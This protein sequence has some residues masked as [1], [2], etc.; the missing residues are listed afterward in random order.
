MVAAVVVIAAI[1][2]LLAFAPEAAPAPLPTWTWRGAYDALIF[3]EAQAA[4]VE[5]ALLKA[6]VAK[7]SNFDPLAINPEETFT[8]QGTTYPAGSSAGRAALRTAIFNGLDP[9]TIGVD[10]SLGL[11]Q[12]RLSTARDRIAG[13]S[14]Q[15][16]FEPQRNLRAS[17]RHIAW[18]FTGGITLD[19]IDAYN[20]GD[21]NL[22]RGVRNLNYRDVVLRFRTQFEHDFPQVA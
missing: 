5:P 14:A 1:F 9:T 7:E 20:V 8:L 11:A 15:Q 17:A 3:T 22:R 13:I 19:T 16:L 4:R 12:V 18:L 2:L 10:P 21:T 6:V